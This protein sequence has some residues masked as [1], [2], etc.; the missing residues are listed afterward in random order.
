[1]KIAIVV[2]T[3][4]VETEYQQF[5][6]AWDT[7]F[8]KHQIVLI[9]VVDGAKHKL[10]IH[11]YA[12]DS[13]E[14]YTPGDYFNPDFMALIPHYCSGCC[15]LGFAWVAKYMPAVDTVMVLHDDVRPFGDTI[16]AHIDALNQ[17]VPISWLSTTLPIGNNLR[18]IYM[19]GFPYEVRDEA[20]VW[21]SHGIWFGVPD[22]DAPSQLVY[23]ENP[24][25]FFYRG[26]VP[27]GIY[28]PFC[29]MNVAA[30]R[31]A[32]PYLYYAPTGEFKGSERFDDIWLG[33]HL[34]RDMAELDAAIVTGYA[35]V[36]HSRASNVYSNLQKES[37]GI[38][39]H[40][41]YWQGVAKHSFFEEYERKRLKWKAEVSTWLK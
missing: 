33:V 18:P 29:G 13:F 9:T 11:D 22:L 32:L 12:V 5:L 34:V 28:L 6:A 36:D 41:G 40:E 26:P 8:R 7:L 38:G 14:N 15:D 37:A 10:I 35:A 30:K 3:I 1:M 17:R 27:K 39:L 19:R 16:Q 24:P 20:E 4:R 2:P 31:K 21:V 25:V 23:G